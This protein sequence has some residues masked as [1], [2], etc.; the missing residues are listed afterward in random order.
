MTNR[1]DPDEVQVIAPNLKRRYSGVTST[2][3]RLVPLQADQIGIATVGPVLPE[4]IPQIRIMDLFT[5][6]RR[7]P[8]GWRVWHARRNTEML[9][10]IL[11]RHVLRKRL[12]LLFTSAAQR[13]HS[14]YTKWLINRMDALVATSGRA[15]AFLDRPATVIRH[16]INMTEFQPPTDRAALRARLGLPPEATIIG[17]FGRIRHQKGNDLF[18]DTMIATL[19][20]HP[21][22]I[23]VIMGGVTPDNAGFVDDLRARI[24]A[25]ALTARIVIL[26]EDKGWTI[27]PWFQACDLYIAPQR[28][29]GFGLTPLEA[30][31]CGVPVIA[32]RVGAFEELIVDDVTGKLIPPDDLPAMIA[33]T[34]AALSDGLSLSRWAAACRPHVAAQFR[35]EH[36]AAALIKIYRRLLSAN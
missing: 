21:E 24:S 10:G 3:L 36:E 32:T 26:P 28:W 16:G 34:H 13:R 23:A 12:K 19:P 33:A 35:I 17:C 1:K 5:M 14:R 9:A 15:A 8:D 25:A 11:L 27:A 2:I 20:A 4:D 30:M 6:S 29:E 7:G 31:A 18:V 22:A